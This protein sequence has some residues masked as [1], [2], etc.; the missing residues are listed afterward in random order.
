MLKCELERCLRE[1]CS[2]VFSEAPT[3]FH[4][5]KLGRSN[6]C[7]EAKVK[8]SSEKENNYA[9]NYMVCLEQSEATSVKCAAHVF[10]T[11]YWRGC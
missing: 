7:T 9:S 6:A 4:C 2:A 3:A 11:V 8:F 5:Y 1:T 10:G